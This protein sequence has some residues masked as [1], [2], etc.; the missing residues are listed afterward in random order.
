M[1]RSGLVVAGLV[2]IA[3]S[4]GLAAIELSAQGKGDAKAGGTVFTVQCAKCH[5]DAGAGD[6]REAAKLKD[7]PGSWTAGGGGLQGMDDQK[8]YDAIAKGGPAVGKARSMPSYPKLSEADI[9][10]LVAYVKTL[11]R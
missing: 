9:W 10:N 6:G 7:K 4:A 11:K 3:W 2:A 5:G 1:N 8:I